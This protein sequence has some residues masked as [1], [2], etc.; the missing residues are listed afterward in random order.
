MQPGVGFLVIVLLAGTS[1]SCKRYPNDRGPL[2]K[3]I[4][5]SERY[6][7]DSERYHASKAADHRSTS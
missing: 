7:S 6:V 1:S 5:S 4:A 3:S 2:T